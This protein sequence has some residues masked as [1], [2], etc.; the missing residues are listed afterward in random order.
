MTPTGLVILLIAAPVFLLTVLR[1]NTA[2]VFLS[3][4][5]GQVLVQ[6]VGTDAASTVGI[7][8]SDGST[9]PSMVA[10]SLLLV[11]AIFTTLIMMRT[12]K[13]KLR[14]IFNILPAIS[15]GIIGLLLAEPL[16]TPGLRAA[17]ESTDIWY[18]ITKLQAFVV[19]VSAILSILFLWLQRPKSHKDDK[20]H[21]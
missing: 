7:I 17:I 3:L 18:L 9:N 13:G 14:L 19:G 10:L 15:V 5:L 6:F 8:A 12:V 16:F 20:R 4:C 1:V 11:P 21:K 2:M